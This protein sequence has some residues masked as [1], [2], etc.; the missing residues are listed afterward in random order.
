M[1]TDEPFR[2]LLA[3]QGALEGHR[4]VPI[5]QARLARVGGRE[6]AEMQFASESE[7]R[8]VTREFAI[9]WQDALPPG[10]EVVAGTWWSAEA[11][12][13]ESWVSVEESLA[14]R[15]ELEVGEEL[16]FDIQGVR[17]A[18]TVNGC[19]SGCSATR[20]SVPTWE[21]ASARR[22]TRRGAGCWWASG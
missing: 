19:G 11:A 13:R 14:R 22:F 21:S 15:L 10:N 7:E 2:A 5:V 20:R 1:I 3:A 17:V 6:V 12:G 18:T 8:S 4:L 9:T 16:V